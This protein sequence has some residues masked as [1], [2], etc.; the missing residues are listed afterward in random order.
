MKMMISQKKSWGKTML[1]LIFFGP[2]YAKNIPMMGHQES[3]SSRVSGCGMQM[4]RQ[5]PSSG[6][7]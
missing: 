7:Q 2:F 3:G 4:Q 6:V 1:T 5:V